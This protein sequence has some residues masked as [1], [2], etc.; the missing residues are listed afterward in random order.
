MCTT[1]SR[2]KAVNRLYIA[3]AVQR[4]IFL[5]VPV[6]RVVSAAETLL[7]ARIC[8]LFNIRLQGGDPQD[9]YT[10]QV[11]SERP[12]WPCES[13]SA[14]RWQQALVRLLTA[15]AAVRRLERNGTRRRVRLV[16]NCRI[17][18]LHDRGDL[19]RDC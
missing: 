15:A 8:P 12:L 1:S 17:E 18:D 4:T 14:L 19:P 6:L 5:P 16:Q 3:N 10:N 7:S 13:A 11:A 2:R 9:V